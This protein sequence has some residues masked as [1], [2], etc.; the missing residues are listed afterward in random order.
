[1]A[2]GEL[3]VKRWCGET[4]EFEEAF[5]AIVLC[6]FCSNCVLWSQPGGQAPVSRALLA[7]DSPIRLLPG[8]SVSE[9]YLAHVAKSW[10]SV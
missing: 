3:R 2:L 10:R 8:L 5:L 6:I 9:T 1:M 4:Q 7:T